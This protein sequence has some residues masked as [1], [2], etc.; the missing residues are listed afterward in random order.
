MMKAR[1]SLGITSYGLA[2]GLLASAH[3]QA[4]SFQV[5]YSFSGKVDGGSPES[6]VVMDKTGSLYGVTTQGGTAGKCPGTASG[7][8]VVYKLTAPKTA[9]GIWVESVL[10]KF[11]GGT[12]GALPYADLIIDPKGEL[13]GTTFAG[14]GGNCQLNYNSIA[15]KGCGTVF[16]L[17]PPAAGK[18]A[19]TESKIYS[20]RGSDAASDGQAPS[21]RLILDATGALFGTTYKG[22]DS[23]TGFC[24]I[25]ACGTAFKL[26]PPANAKAKWTESIIYNFSAFSGGADQAQAHPIGALAIDSVSGSLFGMTYGDQYGSNGTVYKL[27]R[28][29]PGSTDWAL[30]TPYQFG[31]DNDGSNPYAGLIQDKAGIF[32]GTTSEGG[33]YGGGTVFELIRPTGKAKAWTKKT[34]YHFNTNASGGGS[35]S[36]LVMDSTGA[37]YGTASQGGLAGNGKGVVFKLTPPAKGTTRW[38]YTVLHSFAGGSD[39]AYPDATLIIKPGALYG[40]TVSGGSK[41]SG[42]VYKIKL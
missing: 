23:Q 21:S 41:F 2:L 22:G 7:C 8:G 14:G 24:S 1:K 27:D 36:G 17:D 25:D 3:A 28:P 10:Y 39:G 12:D 31:G 18:T 19:W 16:Q 29:A 32:Y 4:T 6:G 42:V 35:I 11:M 15:Y 5:L 9:T 37:L 38:K 30:T 26:V 13:R 34:L 20:F 33:A 40:T